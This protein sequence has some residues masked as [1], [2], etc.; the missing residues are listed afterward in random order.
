MCHH[1]VEKLLRR[2]GLWQGYFLSDLHVQLGKIYPI[3]F[4]LWAQK[5]HLQQ[6]RLQM[7]RDHR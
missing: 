5:T 4:A 3:I 6:F 2:R 7:H 1:V